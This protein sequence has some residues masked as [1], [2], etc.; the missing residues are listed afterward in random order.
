M[1]LNVILNVVLVPLS[2][3]DRVHEVM[4]CEKD[5]MDGNVYKPLPVL[6]NLP[7]DEV[8]VIILHYKCSYA[9]ILSYGSIP[10]NYLIHVVNI[11]HLYDSAVSIRL[12]I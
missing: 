8:C 11:L 5:L 3:I 2:K 4:I 7:F 10:G 9:Y 6:L 12:H 1:V